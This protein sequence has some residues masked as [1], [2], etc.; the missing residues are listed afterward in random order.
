MIEDAEAGG[1]AHERLTGRKGEFWKRL[2]SP[3]PH[4]PFSLARDEAPV[5]DPPGA[6]ERYS[7]SGMAART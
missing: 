5:L 3:Q 4:D 1:L 7:N 6:K 2:L